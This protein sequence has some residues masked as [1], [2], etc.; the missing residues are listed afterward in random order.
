MTDIN[1]K[2]LSEL[3]VFLDT[4]PA[5]IETNILRG[6]LRAGARPIYQAAKQAAPVGDVSEIA[7]FK[8]KLYPGALRDSIRISARID[9]R[10]RNITASIKAG[11]KKRKTGADVFYAHMV[12]FGTRP[13]ALSKGGEVTHPGTAPRPF[14]RPAIDSQAQNA[15]LA[16]GEYIKKRL[17]TKHGLDTAEIEIGIDEE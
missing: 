6:A 5:K 16:A 17:S 12:E 13:H 7:K 8:Y 3:Q 9:R 10:N 4:L 2:G 15:I 11:G 14:M 1:V